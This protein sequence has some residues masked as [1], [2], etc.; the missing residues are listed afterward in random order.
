MVTAGP[1][2]IPDPIAPMLAVDAPLPSSGV[3]FEYKWD[4]YRCCVRVSPTGAVRLT[5]RNGNDV[6]ATYP[7]LGAGLDRVFGGQAAVFDGEIVALDPHSGRPDFQRLQSRHQHQPTERLLATMPVTFFAFDLLL[8]DTHSLLDIAYQQRRELLEALDWETTEGRVVVPPYYPATEID[9]DTL[10]QIVREHNLEGLIAK[11]LD[12]PYQPGKR[13][14]LWTKHALTTTQEVIIG[15]WHPG[16]GRRTGTIGS[17]L[18][19]AHDPHTG[20]LVYIGDVGTG[21]TDRTLQHLHTLLQPLERRTSPFVTPVPADRAR[22]AHWVEPRLVGEVTY[23]A[24]TP[25]HRLRH[26][27]WR[28]LRTNDKKPADVTL[29]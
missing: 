10:L 12:S 16:Q 7:E 22:H 2:G 26:C 27:S 5:S 1:A 25:D 21:F 15:G 24:W 18:L 6:T 28:G 23:R 14:T 11:Y 4:G 3:G 29:P 13:S 17:L 8:L 19:G 20:D 9:P